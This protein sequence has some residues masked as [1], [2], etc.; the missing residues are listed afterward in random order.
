MKLIKVAGTMLSVANNIEDVCA[1]KTGAV[2]ASANAVA[3]VNEARSYESAN[4]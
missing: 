2:A 3:L 4:L 1:G